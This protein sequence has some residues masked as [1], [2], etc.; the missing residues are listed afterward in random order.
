M[1]AYKEHKICDVSCYLASSFNYSSIFFYKRKIII[2]S[3]QNNL[4][5]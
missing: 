4:L 3:K 5:A 2:E 1:D